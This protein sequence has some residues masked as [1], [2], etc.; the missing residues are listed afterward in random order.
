[1]LIKTAV[2]AVWKATLYGNPGDGFVNYLY[3]GNLIFFLCEMIMEHNN[4]VKYV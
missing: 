4:K 2:A 1:V 3:G